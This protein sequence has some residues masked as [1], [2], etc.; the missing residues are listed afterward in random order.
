M[1]HYQILSGAMKLKIGPSTL[2]E[3]SNLR[4]QSHSTGDISL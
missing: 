3:Q 1:T 2:M 4:A